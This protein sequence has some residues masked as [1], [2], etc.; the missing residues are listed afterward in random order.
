MVLR[1]PGHMGMPC[2]PAG[3]EISYSNVYPVFIS[4]F[5]FRTR[6]IDRSPIKFSINCFNH[7]RIRCVFDTVQELHDRLAIVRVS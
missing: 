3:F 7:L 6:F 4:F 1:D 5:S 2:T